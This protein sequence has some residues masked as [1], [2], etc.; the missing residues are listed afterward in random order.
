MVD[1]EIPDIFSSFCPQFI[2]EE[3]KAQMSAVPCMQLA[4]LDFY[5]EY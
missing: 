4:E 3:T 1:L 2:E 5:M